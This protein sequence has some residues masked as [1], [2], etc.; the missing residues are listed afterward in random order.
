MDRY[1]KYCIATL[2][3]AILVVPLAI[4]DRMVAASNG[5]P[6][7]WYKTRRGVLHTESSLVD[8][9]TTWP[10]G[11][12][13]LYPFENDASLDIGFSKFGELIN[14]YDEIGMRYRGRDPF[15]RPEAIGKEA[16]LNGWLIELKYKSTLRTPSDRF[17]WAFALFADGTVWGGDWKTIG[18][19][20]GTGDGGGLGID[21]K[22]VSGLGGRQTNAKVVTDP[23]RMLYDGPRRSVALLVNKIYD[24]N[25]AGGAI[26]LEWP[27]ADLYIT[28]IFNKVKKSVIL[29]KDVCYRLPP[30]E[31]PI[32]V[33]LS[34]REQVDLGPLPDVKSYAHFWHQKFSTC[35]GGNWVNT[36]WI[37]REYHETITVTQTDGYK[38][39]DVMDL[40][41]PLKT[42]LPA[43]KGSEKVYVGNDLQ[44]AG[45]DYEYVSGTT[46]PPGFT[47]DEYWEN[48]AFLSIKWKRIV[49]KG[50][51]IRLEY[52]N[53]MKELKKPE[54]MA[55][56]FGDQVTHKET[57]ESH[58][59][60][61]A[62]YISVDKKFVVFKAFWPTLSSYMLD[63]WEQ[64]FTTI[65]YPPLTEWC[66]EQDCATEPKVPFSIGQWDFM[67]SSEEHEKQFRAVEVLGMIDFHD[68]D[69]HN[70]VDLNADGE[71]P[72]NQV[73]TEA[74]WQLQ[75]VF[76]PWDLNDSTSNKQF[77]RQVEYFFTTTST[78]SVTL[79]KVP[80]HETEWR[81]PDDKIFD[82]K[83][84]EGGDTTTTPDVDPGD[85][86][87]G[88]EYWWMYCTFAEKVLVDGKLLK[89]STTGI[90]RDYTIDAGGKITF[91]TS[92]AS[93]KKIKVLYS[94]K[95]GVVPFSDPSI[96][97]YD[98][99]KA[100]WEWIIVG[101]DS[102][103]VDSAGA[104]LVTEFFKNKQMPVLWSGLD[105]KDVTDGPTVP[106]V[107][108]KLRTGETKD[109]YKA[110]DETVPCTGRSTLKDDWCRTVPVKSSNMISVGGMGVNMFTRYW[111]DFTNA[112][113]EGSNVRALT[114]WSKNKIAYSGITDTVGYGV[115]STYKDIDGTVGFI[116]YGL[117][118]ED[119]FWTS[120]WLWH[121]GWKLQKEP[122]CV[123]DIIL[124][125]D[126]TKLTPTPLTH[127][128]VKY[129]PGY[130]FWEVVEALG[131]ISEF[132]FVG[133]ETAG[134]TETKLI[135]QWTGSLAAE[136][137][138]SFIT[139]TLEA[140]FSERK[141]WLHGCWLWQDDLIAKILSGGV[142]GAPGGTIDYNIRQGHWSS[143]P[144]FMAKETPAPVVVVDG[145][146]LTST[147]FSI[148]WVG[149]T[150]T[151]AKGVSAAKYIYVKF[152][153][154]QPPIHKCSTLLNI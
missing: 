58:Y 40:E 14:G 21:E 129:K 45:V 62:Q 5:D 24:A 142:G 115:I 13:T 17:V 136:T 88:C 147:E 135:Y 29:L 118:G 28:I 150:L 37:L 57:A 7:E 112:Y 81:D 103:A 49:A 91:T 32:D 38:V 10:E 30:K 109:S 63:A 90:T 54:K 127:D 61:L 100:N 105:M 125:F 43:I 89:P 117:T 95:G 106:Y 19:H 50:A 75:E 140:T 42:K 2:I 97:V 153:V 1:S 110:E 87:G 66:W 96:S 67:L 22:A 126:Y 111:N 68:A 74:Y 114:C 102:K 72:E 56:P 77:R 26:T 101:R 69:D 151:L 123:T 55:A 144:F 98:G 122:D 130:C 6:L 93:G 25:V 82:G 4:T 46:N 132:D 92:V 73:D 65:H 83:D 79:Q 34:N 94:V 131:T 85:K 53:I 18:V 133:L 84:T 107:L 146:K 71:T 120:W 12:G 44:T 8:P 116:I 99:W 20:G 148:D 51:V 139:A 143:S 121:F 31:P 119:T 36:K 60:D 104:A 3:L 59:Y 33:K 76:N 16:W 70:A 113:V 149:G 137:K 108:V 39:N 80:E 9:D 78:T 47:W 48:K 23:I 86:Y 41:C 154:K 124:K 15:C 138:V 128:S 141:I 52:K 11:L 145:K 152:N 64:K 35:Y 27:V 134:A